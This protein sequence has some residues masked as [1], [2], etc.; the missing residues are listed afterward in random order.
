MFNFIFLFE[1]CFNLFLNAPLGGSK[2]GFWVEISFI[3]ISAEMNCSGLFLLELIDLDL[4][5]DLEESYERHVA[6]Y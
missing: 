4:E 3:F 5:F 1:C 2:F 6:N